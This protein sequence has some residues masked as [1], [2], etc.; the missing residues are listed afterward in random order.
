[1]HVG[2]MVITGIMIGSSRLFED[3]RWL[4]VHLPLFYL[5]LLNVGPW[6]LPFL[7]LPL[8]RSLIDFFL[9]NLEVLH[10]KNIIINRLAL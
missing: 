6:L 3:L 4:Y 1:M 8:T 7:S 2:L 9:H 10:G 5:S